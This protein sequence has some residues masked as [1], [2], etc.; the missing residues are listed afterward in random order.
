MK[1]RNPFS[2][3]V[4]ARFE[5]PEV[6]LDSRDIALLRELSRDSRQSQRA[7]SRKVGMSP[8]AVAERLA[9]FERTGVVKQYSVA[10]DWERL[11]LGVV[12]I[13]NLTL[14]PAQD[15]QAVV[16]AL[17]AM[18]E[19]EQLTVVTG[20]YDLTAR[21]RIADQG[22]LRELILDRIPELP[23]ILRTETLLGLGTVDTDDFAC[24]IFDTL[25]AD[26][27]SVAV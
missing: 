10:I 25:P 8:P 1:K 4:G 23:G 15:R 3:Y 21:F 13:V 20:R 24:R 7:L 5:Q 14:R 17:T 26:G 12:A 11:G 16:D 2:S 19:L 9:R 27:E 18:V 6:D 22:H